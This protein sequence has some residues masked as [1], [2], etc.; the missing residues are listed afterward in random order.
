MATT[1][2]HHKLIQAAVDLLGSQAK[3]ATA[4]GCSQQ[5]IAYLLRAPRI[6]AEMA[7]AV[8]SA[9]DGKVPKHKLRPDVF[10]APADQER[11]A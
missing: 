6:S 4:M 7:A 9:T 3:L 2:K 8:H 11:A 1:P 10:E 5:Q